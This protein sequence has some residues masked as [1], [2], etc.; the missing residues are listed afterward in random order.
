MGGEETKLQ[1]EHSPPDCGSAAPFVVISKDLVDMLLIHSQIDSQA[2]DYP[3]RH[4]SV[5]LSKT[6]NWTGYLTSHNRRYHL[7]RFLSKYPFEKDRPTSFRFM[8]HIPTEGIAAD[9]LTTEI[10][11]RVLLRSDQEQGSYDAT[12]GRDAMIFWESCPPKLQ[13][14]ISRLWPQRLCGLSNRY[15]QIERAKTS[16]P[17]ANSTNLLLA[18]IVCI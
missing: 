12:S 11:L 17:I 9:T 6:S 7:L 8:H 18:L 13:K 15:T 16:K 14:G 5:S 1:S 3:K 4:A 2:G 10:R